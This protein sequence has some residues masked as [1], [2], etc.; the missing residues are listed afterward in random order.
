LIP[1]RKIPDKGDPSDILQVFP[2]INPE[3]LCCRYW[4][5]KNWEFNELSFPYWRIYTNNRD[6]A[7]ITHNG[8][9]YPL[10]E[11][12]II[13]IAPNTNFSTRLFN[14]PIPK[15]GYV[16]R[17]D[18]VDFST[19]ELLEGNYL[20]HLFIHFNLGTLYD[21]VK[22]GIFEFN[23]S[24]LL[25]KKIDSITSHLRKDSTQ[26][27]FK[28]A[29]NIQSLITHLLSEIEEKD[30]FDVSTDLRILD[31]LDFIENNISQPLSNEILAE[32][33][34]LATNAFNRLFKQETGLSPQKYVRKKRIDKSCVLLHHSGQSIE[35]VAL[36]GGF[37]DRYHFSRIF[38]Q[39]TG[40]SPALYR[41][42]FKLS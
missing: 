14:N 33:V 30:R 16:I 40:L 10:R 41:K 4:W 23:I 13:M 28:V 32:R 39:V 8:I 42:N 29:L 36:A 27:N 2:T 6:G 9:D 5:L 21:N 1:L 20:L 26:F 25:Q 7:V 24:G 15:T 19:E 35:Q 37:A 38:K 17:G 22:P 3:L 12:K 31:T 11:G 34:K 18:K